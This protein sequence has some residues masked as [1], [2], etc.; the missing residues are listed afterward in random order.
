MENLRNLKLE[1]TLI[2][3]SDNEELFEIKKWIKE[4]VFSLWK[5]F[6]LNRILNK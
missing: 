4:L 6:Y 2:H 5:A 1:K 3:M